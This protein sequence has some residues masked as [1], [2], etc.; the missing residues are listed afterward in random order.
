MEDELFGTQS[1]TPQQASTLREMARKAQDRIRVFNPTETDYTVRWDGIGFV[2]PGRVRDNGNGAGQAILPR[3]VAQNYVKHMTDKILGEKM[4]SAIRSENERRRSTGQA[5]M[6]QWE[7]RIQYDTQFRIDNPDAR[8]MVLEVLWL[9]IE[10]EFGMDTPERVQDQ[11]NYDPRSL[12][13]RIL[14]KLD[15]PARKVSG[16]MPT[17]ESLISAVPARNKTEVASVLDAPDPI[18]V[19]TPQEAVANAQE[20]LLSEVSA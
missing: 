7:E 15:R 1:A 20:D 10:E 18:A 2:V 8:R 19:P 17:A 13:E 9:G 3:Y 6:N 5:N 12:D 4:I 14:E 11:G 16:D